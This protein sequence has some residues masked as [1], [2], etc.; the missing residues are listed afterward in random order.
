MNDTKVKKLEIFSI[1]A[2]N[3]DKPVDYEAFF[4]LLACVPAVARSLKAGDRTFAISTLI[5]SNRRAFVAAVEGTEGTRPL[6]FNPQIFEERTQSLEPGEFVAEKTHAVVDLRTREVVVEFNL[7]GPRAS[8]IADVLQ[9]IGRKLPGYPTLTIS[10]NPV[11]DGE[12]VAEIE[13]FSRIKEASVQVAK[14]NQSWTD[15]R[16]SLMHLADES[17]A[18]AASLAMNAPPR[19]TLSKDR[20]IVGII[21]QLAAEAISPFKAVRVTGVRV[22]E[23]SDTTITLSKHQEHRRMPVRLDLNGHVEDADINGRM[24]DLLEERAEAKRESQAEL[25]G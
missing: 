7:R 5:V 4:A 21:K 17:E 8:M 12:F 10:L 16:N 22:G 9:Y 1:H 13:R 25:E 20:G 6:I 24:T 14:P 19:G 15:H 11:A 2:L 18:G 23:N 3:D